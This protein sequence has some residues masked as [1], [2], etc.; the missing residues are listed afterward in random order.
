MQ[1]GGKFS[2]A[3]TKK[4]GKMESA[5][6]FFTPPAKSYFIFG[7]R[8][9]GKSTWVGEHYN[10]ALVVDLLQPEVYRSYKSHPERLRQAI[11]GSGAKVIVIDE[12]QKC[13]A[14]LSLIHSLIESNKDLLFI[15]TGSSSRKLKKE[16]VDLLAGRAALTHMHPFMAAEQGDAFNLQTAIS[17]GM[18]PLIFGSPD[19]ELDLQ[20]YLALYMKEEVQLEGIIRNVEGFAQF[21]EVISFSQGSILNYSTIARDCHVS[22]KTVDNFVSIL[23][24]LLL[25]FKVP[26]FSKKAK[27][28]LVAKP[29]FY[30]FDAGVYRSIRPKG[31]LDNASEISG[32]VLETLVAQHLRAWISYSRQEGG[33]Y[34]WRTK[35]GL[36]VDFVIYGEIGFYAFEVKSAAHVNN[37]DLKG[38]KELRKDYPQINCFLLYMGA[39]T[40]RINDIV[41]MPVET[42]LLS[43][44][45]NDTS[46]AAA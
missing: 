46:W 34:F 19:P 4:E 5:P 1:K 6:R 21:L 42:F 15:L 18:L 35:S 12:I 45:P 37:K 10:D 43:L 7:P 44:I 40:L 22:S 29:K 2:I 39:E 28:I 27:R 8:G 16:G 24:D 30:Y 14:M 41:C 9:T 38:L 17:F 3:I 36:E 11:A 32:T 31:P 20:A 26:V 33:L 25:A 13:P 23:E